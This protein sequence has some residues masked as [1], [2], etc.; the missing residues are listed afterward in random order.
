MDW[1]EFNRQLQNRVSDPGTRYMLGLMYERQLDMAKQL[2]MCSEIISA[3]AETVQGV[4][5]LHDVLD[6]RLK[7]LNRYV[8]GREAGV[9]FESEPLT[10]D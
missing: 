6:G 8:Q 9:T 4:V 10:N 7:M 1:N 3:L 5:G 2:D